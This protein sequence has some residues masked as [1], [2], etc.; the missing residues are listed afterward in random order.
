[1]TY[2]DYDRTISRNLQLFKNIWNESFYK[3]RI[4]NDWE[5]IDKI[6]NKCVG[7]LIGKINCIQILNNLKS[8]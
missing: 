3:Y 8:D 7:I 5:I 6:Q 2:V 4:P 1:M